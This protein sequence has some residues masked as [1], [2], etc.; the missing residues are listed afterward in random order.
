[1]ISPDIFTFL[2]DL[3]HN[4]NRDWFAENKPR[5]EAVKQ[6][7]LDNVGELLAGLTVIDPG[8]ADLDPKK[9]VFRI[10]RDVRFS[11][12]KLP[13]KS[14]MG[15][16]FVEGGKKSGNA[17]YYLHLE[18]GRCFIGGGI[19]MPPSNILKAV[20][21]EVYNFPEDITALTEDSAFKEAFGGISGE[22]L[23]KAPQGFDKDFEHL[24]LLKFK[25][26]TVG[27]PVSEELLTGE[28]GKAEILRYFKTMQPL[29]AFL[30]RAVKENL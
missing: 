18:P 27:R 28:R 7:F 13:Y 6:L 2:N 4:N 19:H 8:V 15:T 21:T 12:D 29:I 5:Y 1:M 16:F 24:E 10:Y 11:K 23:K 26:Y 20:R 25:S 3:K 14:N 17:G 22:K 9:C 30:N